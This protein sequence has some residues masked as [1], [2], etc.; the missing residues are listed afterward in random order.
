MPAG[1]G[2]IADYEN[3]LAELNDPNT[4]PVRKAMLEPHIASLK[5]MADFQARKDAG[6]QSALNRDNSF[7]NQLKALAKGGSVLA[8]GLG[9]AGGLAGLSQATPA[10]GGASGAGVNLLGASAAAPTASGVGGLESFLSQFTGGG[11]GGGAATTGISDALGS[12]NGLVGLGPYATGASAAADAGGGLFS[13][14]SNLGAGDWINLGAKGLQTFGSYNQGKKLADAAQQQAELA[15][16]Q[17]Q[18]EQDALAP[19][20]DRALSLTTPEGIENYYASPEVQGS[21]NANLRGLSAQYGNP[22]NNNTALG[23]ST[24]Y[25]LGGLINAQRSAIN[26]ANLPTASTL[27]NLGGQYLGAYGNQALANTLPGNALA[28]GIGGLGSMLSRTLNRNQV[29][30]P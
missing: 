3:A 20:R 6:D 9:L 24:A 27:S 5:S 19:Y 8:G 25:S 22:A 2:P 21:I 16:Q 10:F 28:Y 17:Y 4:D 11:G 14:L 18:G 23:R 29:G 13:G 7:G 15:R 12:V 30:Q 1:F 26:A